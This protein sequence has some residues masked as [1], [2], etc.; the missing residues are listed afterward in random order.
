MSLLPV[1]FALVLSANAELRAVRL[2]IVDQRTAMRVLTSPEVPGAMVVREGDFVVVKLSAL[3]AGELTLPAL[4]PPLEGLG[5]ERRDDCTLLRIRLAREVPF[6]T[7]HEPGMTTI[8]FGEQPAA[9][10]R[11]AVTPEQYERL[12]P[13]G[14]VAG[15]APEL[16]AAA[17]DARRGEGLALGPV[18]LVPFVHASWVD[19]EVSFD[20]PIPVPERYLQLAPGLTAVLP[21]LDGRLS[22][23]YEPRLRFFSNIPELGH[24]SHLASAKLELP[25]GTRVVLRGSERFTRAVLEANVVDPGR[26]YFFDLSPY[27]ANDASLVADVSLGP[28]LSAQLEGGLRTARFDSASG[29]GFF[30]YDTRTLR[31]GLGYDLGAELKAQVSY[32][33]DDVPRSPQRPIVQ[34][35]GQSLTGTLTGPIGPVMTGTLSGGYSHRRS[36]LASGPSRSYDG[37]VLGASLHRDLG[38]SSSLELGLNRAAL[39]SSFEQNA[40]YVT[41]S[42][43]LAL[44]VPTPL[45]TTLRASLN[46]WQN[47]YPNEAAALGLPRRDRI[48][49][50]SVGVGRRLAARSWLRVDYRRERRDS[51]LPGFDVTTDGFSVQLG[52]SATGAARP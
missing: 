25:L 11:G 10:L 43:A 40:Y 21:L 7:S 16:D 2:T 13:T 27:T 17:V 46:L 26:E 9:E 42:G 5:V 47:D 22:A 29:Q 50:W 39:L 12:F 34:T 30:D 1:L 28:R 19:A 6:E 14:G 48:L 45:Q 33:Y 32:S 24:T 4:Q 49:S 38:H 35:S 23:D 51:N 18:E 3:A 20:N 52:V 44:N 41:N 15:E 36:P 37:L 31:A 8:V